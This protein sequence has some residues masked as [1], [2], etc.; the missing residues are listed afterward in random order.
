MFCDF[1]IILWLKMQNHLLRNV[2]VASIMWAF[3]ISVG[4]YGQL[5]LSVCMELLQANFYVELIIYVETKQKKQGGVS[6]HTP[7][8]WLLMT[9]KLRFAKKIFKIF[10]NKWCQLVED[11]EC[12]RK[13]KNTL[14]S[15]CTGLKK[16]MN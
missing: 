3:C 5:C 16:I 6:D 11:I 8:S 1:Q 14:C 9:A 7:I 2:I 10:K 4:R 13:Y 15:K 12:N